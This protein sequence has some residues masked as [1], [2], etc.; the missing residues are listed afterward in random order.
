M[1]EEVWEEVED[2]HGSSFVHYRIFSGNL[3][4]LVRKA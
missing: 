2:L 3:E 1:A 4:A